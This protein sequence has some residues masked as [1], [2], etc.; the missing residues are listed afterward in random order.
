[1]TVRSSHP[2]PLASWDLTRPPL[3][4]TAT[5]L[6]RSTISALATRGTPPPSARSTTSLSSGRRRRHH[7]R[8]LRRRPRRPRLCA[9]I[10]RKTAATLP[11]TA[12]APDAFLA[13]IAASA[14]IVAVAGATVASASERCRQL[15]RHRM[16]RRPVRGC[17][18]TR[19]HL[20]SCACVEPGGHGPRR[21]LRAASNVRHRHRRGQR[22]A[23]GARGHRPRESTGGGL[24]PL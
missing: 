2:L 8:R 7:R 24:A 10:A 20:R 16:L 13:S 21:L 1:L 14:A 4:G 3:R 12:S 6:R 23:L 22:L 17:K 18:R 19:R 11:A 15:R 9:A 5:G